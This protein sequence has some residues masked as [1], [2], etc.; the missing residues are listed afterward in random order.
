MVI[1]HCGGI[2]QLAHSKKNQGIISYWTIS[3]F[4]V[5]LLTFWMSDRVWNDQLSAVRL[6]VQPGD[7]VVCIR[8]TAPRSQST[9]QS[10]SKN[11]APSEHFA[12][13]GRNHHATRQKQSERFLGVDCQCF[14]VKRPRTLF[15]SG[16]AQVKACGTPL[17]TQSSF[18][19]G[20]SKFRPI[21]D[22]FVLGGRGSYSADTG[23]ALK[24]T[25]EENSEQS[26]LPKR[27]R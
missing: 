27:R 9:Q 23:H 7:N 26:G 22:G 24:V 5:S 21:H 25:N 13:P 11:K 14:C 12:R 8:V 4:C 16:D 19:L 17:P 18:C 3:L 20:I 6:M 1:M 15:T 10:N 2:S